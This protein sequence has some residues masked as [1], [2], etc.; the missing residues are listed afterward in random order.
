[1]KLP[2]IASLICLGVVGCSP[3]ITPLPQSPQTVAALPTPPP[4][5]KV[6][7]VK[8]EV[9]EVDTEE[10]VEHQEMSASDIERRYSLIHRETAN[11]KCICAAGDPFCRCKLPNGPKKLPQE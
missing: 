2:F 10:V 9:A 7:V 4:F 3:A 6:E 11:I 1:M 8:E 5:V